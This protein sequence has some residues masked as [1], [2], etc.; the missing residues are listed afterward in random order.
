MLEK[1]KLFLTL[2]E[3]WLSMAF[4]FILLGVRLSFFYSDYRD[5]IVKPFYYTEVEVLQAYEKK[6]KSQSY[7]ILKL[8][9]SKLNLNFFTRTAKL[10]NPLTQVLRIKVF[11][12]KKMSFFDYLGTSFM[13][14][15]IKEEYP[16]TLDAKSKLLKSIA[17]QHATAMMSNF[18]QAIFFAEP[19]MKSLRT[20]VST[21]G[22]SHLIALSGFHLAILST[23][24]FFL[25]R[26]L[27]RFA[28]K[29]YFPYRFDL[30]D[31]GFMVLL[32]LAWYVWFVDAPPSLLRSYMMLFIAWILLF[33]GMELLSFTFLSFIVM[34]LLVLFPK[35]LLS[36]A[37]WF[38]VLGVFY[39]FLLL[40]YWSHV[41]KYVMTVIISFAIFLLMLPVVHMVF[42]VVSPLQLL[43]PFLSL[44]FS[45]F[46]PLSMGLH[47]IGMGN[48]FDTMLIQLFT[49]KY[50]VHH[51]VVTPFYGGAYL[52]LSLMALYS[53]WL[54]YFL[55]LIA[56]GFFVGLFMGFLL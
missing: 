7:I 56:F 43:S 40:R 32:I 11:P 41:N 48:L 25:L 20:Q 8:H 47:L 50:P 26:P 45:M 31:V 52:L 27:Y 12:N 22:V 1:P 19:L 49:L 30:L 33:F 28:Q 53:R 51:V 46:Y 54:F 2:K 6:G 29:R 36:L 39:I 42:P 9:S 23:L 13:H 34:L 44:V 17:D 14:S 35:M 10:D 37:F 5:F 55:F 21:L 4:L 24:L 3:F 38:S 16:L 15:Q 18:Y